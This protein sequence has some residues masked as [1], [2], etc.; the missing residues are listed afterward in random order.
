[1][2]PKRIYLVTATRAK[3]EEEF[4]KRPIAKSLDKLCSMYDTTQF[5]FDVVKDNKEGL[6]TVYNRYI[7]EKYKDDIV[8]F[9]HDDLII[10]D[11]F[12]IEKLNESP[13][14]VT[15]LAGAQEFNKSV[16]MLAW[17]LAASRESLRGEVAHIKDGK[18]FTTTFG[19]TPDR[20][21]TFDGVFI[22][23]NVKRCLQTNTK[24]IEDFN[25]H[26]YDIAF[27]LECSKNKLKAGV[28]PIRVIHYGLGDSMLTPEWGQTN[29]KF[30]Q[31]YC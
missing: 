17:H 10:E 7:V 29:I 30:K 13:Y 31:I 12:L 9:V 27:S 11:L 24:F 6:S 26:F 15:A 1:M 3:T 18:V 8:L 16:P 22:A 21:V 25:F 2:K 5:D 19:P 20:V 28:L 14:D 23:V 4:K